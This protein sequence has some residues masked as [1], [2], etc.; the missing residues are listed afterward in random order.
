MVVGNT[1]NKGFADKITF[2][3]LMSGQQPQGNSRT[4][5]EAPVPA[6]AKQILPIRLRTEQSTLR[7]SYCP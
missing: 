3:L 1:G 4:H 7:K 2:P 6:V 5:W